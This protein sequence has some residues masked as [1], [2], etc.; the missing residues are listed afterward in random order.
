MKELHKHQQNLIDRLFEGRLP[1][2]EQAILKKEME[3]DDFKEAVEHRQTLRHMFAKEQATD[4]LKKQMQDIEKKMT[5]PEE[6]EVLQ[7][8]S[9]GGRVVGIKRWL[10]VAAGV[11]ILIVAGIFLIENMNTADPIQKNFAEI[12]SLQKDP[13]VDEDRSADTTQILDSAFTAC[14]ILYYKGSYQDAM[15]CFSDIQNPNQTDFEIKYYQ[16]V[17]QFQL[18]Q[19]EAALNT[20]EEIIDQRNFQDDPTELEKVKWN[21]LLAQIMA[22]NEDF[23]AELQAYASDPDFKYNADARRLQALLK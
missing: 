6:S 21:R 16:G 15:G 7:P 12:K 17:S 22:G 13:T 5:V 8:I 3:S 9:D 23:E 20:F 19:F 2:S 10:A 18:N 1:K 14:K 4:P 11:A